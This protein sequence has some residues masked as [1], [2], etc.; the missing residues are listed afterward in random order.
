MPANGLTENEVVK[1]G[2]AVHFRRAD[3][4]VFGD[5]F[6]RIIAYPSPLLLHDLQCFYQGGFFIRH[7]GD[8][9][10]NGFYFQVC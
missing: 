5:R 4:E 1:S 8:F 6:H 3:V 10:V 9:V 7:Q 2:H